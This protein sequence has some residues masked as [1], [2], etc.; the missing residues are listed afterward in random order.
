M[1]AYEDLMAAAVAA[2]S[3][4]SSS[5]SSSSASSSSSGSSSSPTPSAYESLMSRAVSATGG[6]VN[7]LSLTNTSG[8]KSPAGTL[9]QSQAETNNIIGLGNS[10]DV[11]P[12]TKQS[13][14]GNLD[15]SKNTKDSPSLKKTTDS[16]LGDLVSGSNHLSTSKPLTSIDGSDIVKFSTYGDIERG[17]DSNIR[18]SAAASAAKT[19]LDN[20]QRKYDELQLNLGY[21]LDPESEAEAR[22]ALDKQRAVL[23]EAEKAYSKAKHDDYAAY[24]SSLSLKNDFATMGAL[25][26]AMSGNRAEQSDIYN[27]RA[28]IAGGAPSSGTT[29]NWAYLTDDEKAVYNYLLGIGDLKGAQDF[30]DFS[31]SY[32]NTREGQAL[33]ANVGNSTGASRFIQELDMAARSGLESGVTGI[34]QNFASDVIAPSASQVAS[35]FISQDILDRHEGSE[36]NL[37][38]IVVDA[39]STITNMIPSLIAGAI[40]PVAGAVTIGLSSK[41]NTYRD[42]INSGYSHV[43]ASQVSTI[44]GVAEATTSYLIGGISKLGGIV[45]KGAVENFVKNL[46]GGIARTVLEIGGAIISESAEEWLQNKIELATRNAYLYENNEIKFFD[47]DDLY[48]VVLTAITTGL[49][50]APGIISNNISSNALGKSVVAN[51][52]QEQLIVAAKASGNPEVITFASELASGETKSTFINLG[53]LAKQ[54]EATGFDLSTLAKPKVSAEVVA[55]ASKP[56]SEMTTLEELRAAEKLA[57]FKG[58]K[59]MMQ[60]IND[61]ANFLRDKAFKAS[62]KTN[63]EQSPASQKAASEAAQDVSAPTNENVQ[64]Q[65]QESAEAAENRLNQQEVTAEEA[66]AEESD[67][68][69]VETTENAVHDAPKE[70]TRSMSDIRKELSKVESSIKVERAL[71][72]EVSPDL[73]AKRDQLLRQLDSISSDIAEEERVSSFDPNMS[74]PRDNSAVKRVSSTIGKVRVSA[75]KLFDAYQQAVN[76]PVVH[77]R[78]DGS[79]YTE[80]PHETVLHNVDFRKLTGY[81]GKICTNLKSISSSEAF[82]SLDSQTKLAASNAELLGAAYQYHKDH[83]SE[84][85]VKVNSRGETIYVDGFPSIVIDFSVALVSGDFSNFG[86]EFDNEISSYLSSRHDPDYIKKNF[87][88]VY[89]SLF[90]SSPDGNISDGDAEFT[91]FDAD[92]KNISDETV[93]DMQRNKD[94]RLSELESQKEHLLSVLQ[95]ALESGDTASYENLKKQLLAIENEIRR[96]NNAEAE[97]THRLDVNYTGGSQLA[98]DIL[99]DA[100]VRSRYISGTGE[101]LGISPKERASLLNLIFPHKDYR[102]EG[103]LVLESNKRT[104]S[105]ESDEF[106]GKANT[107]YD[108]LQFKTELERDAILGGKKDVSGIRYLSNEELRAIVNKKAKSDSAEELTRLMVLK[109]AAKEEIAK[110]WNYLQENKR[111]AQAS[112]DTAALDA[113]VNELIGDNLSKAEKLSI[114]NGIKSS[115]RALYERVVIHAQTMKA[116][117]H[118]NF[119]NDYLERFDKGVKRNG[120][121]GTLIESDQA[122]QEQDSNVEFVGRALEDARGGLENSVQSS[123]RETRPDD[124]RGV[125]EVP[126]RIRR[127]GKSGSE[128]GLGQD[129]ERLGTGRRVKLPDAD[130]SIGVAIDSG[131]HYYGGAVTFDDG[132]FEV[133]P[134]VRLNG[135]LLSFAKKYSSYAVR[136]VSKAFF[137]RGSTAHGLT[138]YDFGE[139]LLKYGKDTPNSLGHEILHE[140]FG[141]LS[142]KYGFEGRYDY[143]FKTANLAARR[144]RSAGF[145]EVFTSASAPIFDKYIKHYENVDR[146]ILANKGCNESEINDSI[147]ARHEFYRK[148]AWEEVINRL[149]C[150]SDSDR[151]YFERLGL[152]LSPVQ[153]IVRSTLVDSGVVDKNFWTDVDSLYDEFRRFIP[154]TR[155]YDDDFNPV[156]VPPELDNDVADYIPNSEYVEKPGDPITY[157][158]VFKAV[159]L[160]E[161]SKEYQD[162]AA[163]GLVPSEDTDWTPNR[164]NRNFSTFSSDEDFRNAQIAAGYDP[165]ASLDFGPSEFSFSVGNAATSVFDFASNTNLSID[166]DILSVHGDT[167]QALSDGKISIGDFSEYYFALASD[168]YYADF[169]DDNTANELVALAQIR[170]RA[171]RASGNSISH[172]EQAYDAQAV[173]FAKSLENSTKKGIEAIQNKANFSEHVTKSG[174]NAFSAFFNR[175]TKQSSAMFRFLGDFDS[176]S[177]SVQYKFAQDIDDATRIEITLS[178]KAH[179]LLGE[180]ARSTKYVDFARSKTLSG[181]KVGSHELTMSEAVSVVKSYESLS[182]TRSF[183]LSRIS[184]LKIDGKTYTVDSLASLY[185]ECRNAVSSDETASKFSGVVNDVVDYLAPF[186]Q[187]ASVRINGYENDRYGFPSYIVDGTVPVTNPDGST[188][189]KVAKFLDIRSAPDTLGAFVFN[190]IDNIAWGELGQRLEAMNKSTRGSEGVGAQLSKLNSQYSTW[191]D[192][193]IDRVKGTKKNESFLNAAMRSARTAYAAG[194]LAFSPTVP[195]KQISSYWA[196]AGVLDLDILLDNYKLKLGTAFT[197]EEAADNVIVQ[198]RM[199]SVNGEIGPRKGLASFEK[200]KARFELVRNFANMTNIEDYA[201]IDNLFYATTE[202]V[203]RDNPDLDVNSAEFTNAVEDKFAEVVIRTQPIFSKK[204]RAEYLSSDNEFV[205]LLSNFRTQQT[206]NLSNIATA[207]GEFIH[208]KSSGIESDSGKRLANTL[209]G[210]V[211]SYISFATLSVIADMAMHRFRKFDK[212]SDDEDFDWNAGTIGNISLEQIALQFFGKLGNVAASNVPLAG[213]LWNLLYRNATNN[214]VNDFYGFN[215]GPATLLYDTGK[216]LSI[217]GNNL[218]DG[219]MNLKDSYT[220]LKYTTQALGVP[221]HNLYLPINSIVQFARDI[222]AAANGEDRNLYESLINEL[223]ANIEHEKEMRGIYNAE[224]SFDNRSGWKTFSDAGIS[225]DEYH[226]ISEK[227]DEI[228]HD[229]SV[230]FSQKPGHFSVWLREQDFSDAQREFIQDALVFPYANPNTYHN[231]DDLIG[232]GMSSDNALA[233]SAAISDGYTKAYASNSNYSVYSKL[234]TLTALGMSDKQ[235]DIAASKYLT[236]TQLKRYTA[237]RAIG[238]SPEQASSEY[239][240]LDANGDGKL[241]Q[242]EL[243]SF[244]KAHPEY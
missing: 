161:M 18:A 22:A 135:G 11:D 82:S 165:D 17:G 15:S 157:D 71:Y 72:G 13:I 189:S 43:Q 39:A 114:L 244:A 58:D 205:R 33:A 238:L 239:R 195:I 180:L 229:S 85:D 110:R 90:N 232:L 218:V 188:S 224:V 9:K 24:Y 163:R 10:F 208:D 216:A 19:T 243:R 69:P 184:G 77:E 68:T 126:D 162:K 136:L 143:S 219:T 209:S 174:G 148:R 107:S 213:D 127:G 223:S 66:T 193:Y 141:N 35:S 40:N 211:A 8:S 237:F 44:L 228:N 192:N 176:H 129:G 142:S 160:N 194:T 125:A 197:G 147:S 79:T 132:T 103:G 95:N 1:S 112:S 83:P 226:T 3:P 23:A 89:D 177:D 149:S 93:F 81:V 151:Q 169:F 121:E 60:E 201:T 51:D 50:E 186:A 104:V 199:T 236:E 167:L 54:V 240:N 156:F 37:E 27:A 137:H 86:L 116:S 185:N 231:V 206:Q 20:E 130:G 5:G 172:F 91:F 62:G 196:A 182:T 96:L 4:S 122:G 200:L 187:S 155:T 150:L 113:L 99:S 210:Q 119:L 108:P 88:S 32:V 152:D 128:R 230:K 168:D 106:G 78:Q 28:E 46:S 181:V 56:I 67:S 171:S 7:S 42:L 34:I 101:F 45:T 133:M 29:S 16:I 64:K 92:F 164:S 2:T 212:D 158:T 75:Q 55:A 57:L 48:T 215:F 80:S 117:R 65:T 84:R 6:N 233:V 97:I 146:T 109:N 61:R 123:S 214:K 207:L 53:N 100:E 159:P 222:S 94:A 59:A 111:K 73:I 131:M 179:A 145:I 175:F 118:G 234:D 87:S 153:E 26:A 242:E 134:S 203:K 115:D 30:L 178:T 12:S 225:Y 138:I 49:L 76:N 204:A 198:S 36:F 52:A 63:V 190:T 166:T 120:T 191:L 102:V 47:K 221:L 21:A 98:S 217:F 241:F 140:R 144:L 25:G 183:P 124:G 38:K 235:T 70:E 173:K 220:A 105:V 202:Q 139:I 154:P 74:A 31:R 170:E 41:G 227:F 14:A